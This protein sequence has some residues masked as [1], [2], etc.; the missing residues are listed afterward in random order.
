MG[1]HLLLRAMIAQNFDCPSVVSQSLWI[2][3]DT[4]TKMDNGAAVVGG[5]GRVSH[6]VIPEPAID[7][8]SF[9]CLSARPVKSAGVTQTNRSVFQSVLS[10][11][12]L[13]ASIV[14]RPCLGIE[15][16]PL[17]LFCSSPA[18]RVRRAAGHLILRTKKTHWFGRIWQATVC[19]LLLKD[20]I[21]VSVW[22]TGG[23]LW[24]GEHFE[25]GCFERP[26][27]ALARAPGPWVGVSAQC[28]RAL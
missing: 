10:R 25:R 19:C 7:Y 9:L 8:P 5:G 4:E 11:E 6:L 18:G 16:Q 26:I 24:Q 15:E 21:L 12:Y 17:A 2:R 20:R 13:S 28:W 1:K 3:G 23:V 14:R 22:P 27:G